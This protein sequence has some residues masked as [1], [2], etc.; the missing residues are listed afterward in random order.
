MREH[1]RSA[2][3]WT[4]A[5]D[6]AVGQLLWPQRCSCCAAP[7]STL[8]DSASTSACAPR[9][10]LV[11]CLLGVSFLLKITF[12][13]HA[14]LAL[15]CR[16]EHARRI[17]L[18]HECSIE[19]LSEQQSPKG[20]NNERCRHCSLMPASRL[21]CLLQLPHLPYPACS[22]Y[23]VIKSPQSSQMG[24]VRYRVQTPAVPAATLSH[25][26]INQEAARSKCILSEWNLARLWV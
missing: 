13:V 24:G 6:P 16:L 25:C 26:A 9:P 19:M 2:H 4:S 3:R 17:L 23:A 22:V 21:P 20:S 15:R 11:V 10:R 18:Y 12:S 14:P 1:N 7:S 8:S 5:P